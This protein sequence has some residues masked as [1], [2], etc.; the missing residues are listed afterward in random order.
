MNKKLKSEREKK[1]VFNNHSSL[2]PSSPFF[3]LSTK[4]LMREDFSFIYPCLKAKKI[5]KA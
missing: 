5:L 1:R 4:R 3:D 2:S